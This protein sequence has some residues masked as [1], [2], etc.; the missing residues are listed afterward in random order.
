MPM[1]NQPLGGFGG[2]SP[3][4][5]SM[6][7][8]VQAARPGMPQGQ[9]PQR[10]PPVQQP[11]Q[12]QANPLLIAAQVLQHMG[13]RG[14]TL[15]VHVNPREVQLLKANGG[16]GAGGPRPRRFVVRGGGVGRAMRGRH[17]E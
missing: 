11:Q 15:L 12:P 14:D 3:S 6:L 1:M 7:M 5:L 9:G 16:A 13:N 10:M 17:G 8:S 4:L 2:V